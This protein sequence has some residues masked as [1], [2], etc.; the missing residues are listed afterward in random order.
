[1]KKQQTKIAIDIGNTSIS[2]ADITTKRI[3]R[4]FSVDSS[5]K[6]KDIEKMICKLNNKYSDIDNVYI[7]SVVPKTLKVVKIAIKKILNINAK[8][9]GAD[10]KVPVKNKYYNKAQVGQDRLV[11]A[12][13]AKELLGSPVVI[14][15]FGTAITIDVVS[16]KG[17]YE[18]G[19]IIPGI[20]LSAESLF[21]KAALLPNVEAIKTPKR[22]IGKNTE[23]SILS[24][25]F[26]GYG[27][28]CSCLIRSIST[29]IKASPKVVVTG[30]YT[31]LM[32]KYLKVKIDK[33]DNDLIFKG[34]RL[35]ISS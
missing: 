3:V 33:I 22:L 27:A 23:E 1:M 15:D 28:M 16:K 14:I 7:C 25:I 31:K 20:R 35:L 5:L 21:N 34:I 18:G 6:Q 26:F 2:F 29:Q 30:G 4:I 10:I 32:K 12:Y 13:I 11:C 19:L 17:E 8:V 9:I 24:G